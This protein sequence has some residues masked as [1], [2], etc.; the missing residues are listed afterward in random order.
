[1]QKN[2]AGNLT[3]ISVDFRNSQQVYMQKLESKVNKTAMGEKGRVDPLAVLDQEFPDDIGGFQQF[4]RGFTTLQLKQVDDMESEQ[5][6][7]TNQIKSLQS[8]IIE[9]HEVFQDMYNLVDEQGTMLDQIDVLVEN[10]QYNVKAAVIELD[11]AKEL[12]KKN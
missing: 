9:L 12:Q 3:H 7:Y 2:L 6:E 4:D 10:T 11:K 8:N 1:M 5:V